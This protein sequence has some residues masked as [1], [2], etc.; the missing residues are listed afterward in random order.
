MA[1]YEFRFLD[2]LKVP[3]IVQIHPHPDDASALA[4]GVE[5]SRTHAI[6]VW[7]DGILV[8][9]VKKAEAPLVRS[10]KSET[11]KGRIT[12]SE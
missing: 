10:R 2:R 12:N 5:L 6:E 1:D 7:K 4:Q 3:V 11:G 8:A 9:R